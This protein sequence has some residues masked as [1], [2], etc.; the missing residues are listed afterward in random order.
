MKTLYFPTGD[1][2]ALYI[3]PT[4]AEYL[5][6]LTNSFTFEIIFLTANTNQALFIL[7]ITKNS[8]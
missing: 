3:K 6:P 8:S 4:Q 5:N 1:S 7:L 2:T